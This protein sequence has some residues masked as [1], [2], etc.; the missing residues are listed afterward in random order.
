MPN[1]FMVQRSDHKQVLDFYKSLV[2]YT[3]QKAWVQITAAT[4]SGNSLRQ[5]AHTHR[6][7]VHQ[8][9]KLG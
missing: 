5:T 4:L 9:V 8:A 1:A 7:F 6:A 2:N 3:A